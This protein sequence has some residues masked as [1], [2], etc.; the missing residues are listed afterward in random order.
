MIHF[1]F[2]FSSPYGYLASTQLEALA[3]KHGVA[4]HWHPILLGAVFKQTGGAPLTQIPMKGAYSIHDFH[5]SAEFYG[6]PFSM[7]SQFPISGVAAARAA[8]WARQQSMAHCARLS[9]ALFKALYVDGADIAQAEVVIA[10]AQAA[11]FDGAA[12]SEALQSQ[13]IKDALKAEVEEALANQVFGSPFFIVGG[14]S[15]WGADRLPQI[16]WWLAK[17]K[18]QTK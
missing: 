17:S 13:G 7:P 15:F 6:V 18:N 9:H 10:T 14:E 2:D 4:V 11:G 1:Y 5:R 8:L 16:D 12:L 3:A